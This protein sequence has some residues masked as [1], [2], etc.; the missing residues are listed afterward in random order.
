[1]R[2]ILLSTA[3]VVAVAVI[4]VGAFFFMPAGPATM[5][6]LAANMPTGAALIA[7]GKYLTQA[8]DCMACHTAPGG[9]PYAGGRAFTLPFGTL[10]STNITADKAT[11]IG[12]YTDAEF[13]RAI[14]RGVGRN[15]EM[16]YPAMPYAS[17]ALMKPEDVVAIKAYLFSLPTVQQAPPQDE[18]S[19]PYNQRYALRAWRLL[20]VPNH[21]FQPDPSQSDA[22]NE[23][24]YLAA[25]GHCAE[26]HTPRNE[27]FAT[28]R[29]KQFAG[30][31]VQ[32][33]DAYNISSDPNIGIGGW[34]DAALTSYFSTGQADGHGVAGGP[35]AEVV[36]DSLRY[37][38][39]SDTSD[40]VA[41]LR[42]VPAQAGDQAMVVH[43][44]LPSLQ[45]STPFAPAPQ[46]SQVNQLGLR[47]FEGSC[48]SCHGWNGQ[49]VFNGYGALRG[50]Q[51][52]SDPSAMNL[53]QV[54]LNGTGIDTAQ[55]RM[56]MPAFGAEYSNAEIAALANYVIAHFGGK[57]AHITAG[58]VNAARGMNGPAA[59]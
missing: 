50:S 6:A 48:V 28:D 40:L 14:R 3:A 51:T 49:G 17:Y 44:D 4:A 45:N 15:G 38:T 46:E 33:W 1:M 18:L 25:L 36:E 23:G 7:R 37:L 10:Y 53:L 47:L 58:D 9:Q 31:V 19:F 16:L 21:P 56:A 55:G 43:A 54:V 35:M 32:G 2:S 30:A 20:F 29:S 11:G 39:P 41:Y 13:I 27:F 59:P 34:S 26:C 57:T 24:A 42:T 12:N 8:A 5:Q 52:V 22:V